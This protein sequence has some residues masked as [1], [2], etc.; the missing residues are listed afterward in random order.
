ML[1][2]GR[3]WPSDVHTFSSYTTFYSDLCQVVFIVLYFFHRHHEVFVGSFAVFLCIQIMKPA[4]NVGNIIACDW[5]AFIIE[6]VA[7]GLYVIEPHRICSPL[8]VLAKISTAVL[9]SRVRLEYAV[10]HW[11]DGLQFCRSISSFQ[12]VGVLLLPKR[13]PS[14]TITAALPPSLS[15]WE[16]VLRI[17][18]LFSYYRPRWVFVHRRLLCP[19]YLEGGLASTKLA[20]SVKLPLASLQCIDIN[21][22]WVF[23]SV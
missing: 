2:F 6:A 8:L 1:L 20:F 7:V 19:S 10:W 16:W 12:F 17:V 4:D 18:I 11:D 23:N 21:Q 3:W 22:L 15:P 13:T 9:Y 14:G 5:L